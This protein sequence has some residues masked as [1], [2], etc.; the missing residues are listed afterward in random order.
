MKVEIVNITPAMASEWLKL[1]ITNRRLRRSVVDGIK[2]A[3]VRGEYIPTH[4]GIAFSEDGV[5]LDGQ[6]R[7]TA[8][9]ELRDGMFPMLV[10]RGVS[11]DAFKV[12]DIGLKRTAADSLREDDRRLVE[13][14]R[15]IA[16]ICLSK[17]SSV[18]PSML[19][20]VIDAIR[21]T[22][23]ALLAFCPTS[24]KTWSATSVRA[25]AV[26]TIIEGGSRDYVKAVYRALVLTD[27]DA[28]PPIARALYKSHVNGHVR[29]SDH[30]DM[31]AR[32]LKVFD[33]RNANLGKLQINTTQAALDRLRA[34]F[35]HLI[36]LEAEP[37]KKAV[38]GVTAKGVLPFN[39]RTA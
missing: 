25:A 20:P 22:H 34:A 8:I 13:V 17:R 35:G 3:L 33:Q 21:P 1:N 36:A 38:N 10:A 26:L 7:L 24:V 4:Q 30:A 29:A 37:K 15:L 2:S 32:C 28:M 31:I 18:T 12:M 6:H 27:F 5:L 14:A 16:W 39:Y 19:E 11:N 23:N 9:S